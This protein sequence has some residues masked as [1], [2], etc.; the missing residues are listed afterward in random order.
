MILCTIIRIRCILAKLKYST[1]PKNFNSSANMFCSYTVGVRLRETVSTVSYTHLDVY[2]RQEQM[3]K[4]I[5]KHTKVIV[6]LH[7][8]YGVNAFMISMTQVFKDAGFDVVCPDYICLLYTSRC[9]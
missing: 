4:D 1:Y 6:L 2:M 9:V 7:E 3:K 8:I 5:L